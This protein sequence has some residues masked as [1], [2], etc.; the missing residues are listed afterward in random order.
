[1]HKIYTIQTL[2]KYY[3]GGEYTIFSF[4]MV[5]GHPIALHFGT[6]IGDI[7][8]VCGLDKLDGDIERLHIKKKHELFI[9]FLESITLKVSIIPI[10]HDIKYVE[11]RFHIKLRVK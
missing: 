11:S 1:M 10:H 8:T 2:P 6:C 7:T 5:D 9:D 3:F 4:D